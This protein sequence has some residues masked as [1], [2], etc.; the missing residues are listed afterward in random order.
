MNAEVEAN[1]FLSC[2]VLLVYWPSLLV[3]SNGQG[4]VRLLVELGTDKQ[5]CRSFPQEILTKADYFQLQLK[6]DRRLPEKRC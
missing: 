4:Q 1:R 6:Y 3:E 2:L 5:F